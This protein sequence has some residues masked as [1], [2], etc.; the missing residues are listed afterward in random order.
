MTT[1]TYILREVI[2]KFCLDC[3]SGSYMDVEN[4]T[5]YNCRLRPYRF[6]TDPNPNEKKSAI[7]KERNASQKEGEVPQVEEYSR[8]D[9]FT[10]PE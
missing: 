8:F 7:M 3:V 4:C 5:S 2:R 1:K 10:L 6:G 9:V